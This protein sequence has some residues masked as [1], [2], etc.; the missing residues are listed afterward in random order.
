MPWIVAIYSKLKVNSMP[1]CGREKKSVDAEKD[2]S[3]SE[4]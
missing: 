3:V 4:R 1:G 2:E